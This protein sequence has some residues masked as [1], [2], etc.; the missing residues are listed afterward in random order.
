MNFRGRK[1]LN[2]KGKN[3]KEQQWAEKQVNLNKNWMNKTIII[4]VLNF[5]S[6]KRFAPKHWSIKQM[7]LGQWWRGDRQDQT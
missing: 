4:T 1:K 7:C 3:G 6:V 2:I 5:R